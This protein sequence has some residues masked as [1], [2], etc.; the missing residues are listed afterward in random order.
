[1]GQKVFDHFDFIGTNLSSAQIISNNERQ[2][3]DDSP[4]KPNIDFDEQHYRLGE[5]LKELGNEQYKSKRY[6]QAIDFYTDAIEKC[7]EVWGVW[8]SSP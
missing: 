3:S 4:A 6:S 8:G 5:E 2:I 1:M 7:F